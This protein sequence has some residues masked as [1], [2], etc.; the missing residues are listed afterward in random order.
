MKISHQ[1]NIRAWDKEE[2]RMASVGIINFMAGEV[3]LIYED[4]TFCYKDTDKAALTEYTGRRDK[5]NTKA[6]MGDIVE[7]NPYR[8]KKIK[9]FITKDEYNTPY[10]YAIPSD[11]A[12]SIKNIEK[13]EIVGNIFEMPE[14]A[15]EPNYVNTL[16]G[17]EK[18][19]T[20]HN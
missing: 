16:L 20:L 1:R 8:L 6:Y 18:E 5:N 10:I 15:G 13:G 7:F 2:K 17:I 9:G 3:C 19:Q 12:Y 14:F 4:A 11:K